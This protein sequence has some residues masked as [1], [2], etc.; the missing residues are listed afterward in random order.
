M[1]W[2]WRNRRVKKAKPFSATQQATHPGLVPVQRSSDETHKS[3]VVDAY[4]RRTT[5]WSPCTCD[6]GA[7]H[8][9]T[10]LSQMD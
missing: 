10:R 1:A 7:D 3:H 2:R 8:D 4:G 6:V 5:T 9:R